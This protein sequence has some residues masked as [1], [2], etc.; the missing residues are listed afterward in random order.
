MK[1]FSYQS[2]FTA[3]YLAGMIGMLGL[4]AFVYPL[5]NR[6]DGLRLNRS[7]VNVPFPLL[8]FILMI[9]GLA[10]LWY[11]GHVLIAAFAWWRNG[12]DILLDDEGILYTEMRGTRM[13]RTWRAYRQ[14]F[15]VRRVVTASNRMGQESE[16]ALEVQFRNGHT[17]LFREFYFTSPAVFNSFARQFKQRV[18][19][20]RDGVV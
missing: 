16:L 1:R 9:G 2:K 14:V 12:G 13:K 8:N 4:A 5:F 18:A 20:A 19:E 3:T 10:G 6:I 15:A 11:A 17:A 7:V